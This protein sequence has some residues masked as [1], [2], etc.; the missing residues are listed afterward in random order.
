MSTFVLKLPSPEG[1]ISTA[2]LANQWRSTEGVFLVFGGRL[3]TRLINKVLRFSA[4]V[5]LVN[6]G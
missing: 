6:R 5:L 1:A 4:S 2:P 3:L